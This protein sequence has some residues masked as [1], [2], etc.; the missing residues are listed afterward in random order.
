MPTSRDCLDREPRRS[1]FSDETR[2]DWEIAA[3]D[4]RGGLL[5]PLAMGFRDVDIVIGG[6]TEAGAEFRR[7]LDDGPGVPML[8]GFSDVSPPDPAGEDREPLGEPN[9]LVRRG[10]GF[11]KK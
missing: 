4:C 10:T 3:T 8:E 9:L 2:S 11:F 1:S 7:H 6:R 5:P